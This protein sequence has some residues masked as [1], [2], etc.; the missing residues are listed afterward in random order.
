[1]EIMCYP[2]ESDSKDERNLDEGDRG[3]HGPS[4]TR[5]IKKGGGG[6]EEEREE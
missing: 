1:M 2:Q 5:R 3:S 4:R 6:T